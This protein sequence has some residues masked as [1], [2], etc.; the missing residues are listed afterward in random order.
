M[1][2][3]IIAL[4]VT[5][6][7]EFGYIGLFVMTFLESTFTPIPSEITVIPAGYLIH[8]GEMHWLPVLF[9]TIG[10]T[11]CGSYFT[12]WIASRFGR[13]IVKKYGNY[14]L[15]TEGKLKL[16]EKYFKDHGEISIFTARLIPGI[17]HVISFPAGLAHMNLR[18]FLLYTAVGGSLWISILL[19]AGYLIGSNREV[20]GHYVPYIK[21]AVLV[22]AV[23]L[24]G[25]Y[26]LL[27][28]KKRKQKPKKKIR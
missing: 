10:G 21:L 24:I 18:K 22:G 28:K 6:V 20:I 9:S 1:F 15:F 11:M 4:I 14:V 2:E 27:H 16:V 19:V 5:F 23:L 13:K 26:M 7:K 17:R 8:Q 3:Q 25:G 12:Y